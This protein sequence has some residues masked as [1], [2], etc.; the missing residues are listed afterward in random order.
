MNFKYGII[1][2]EERLKFKFSGVVSSFSI[3]ICIATVSYFFL[4]EY[5]LVMRIEAHNIDKIYTFNKTYH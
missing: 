4:S 1:I 3:M 2:R 5:R